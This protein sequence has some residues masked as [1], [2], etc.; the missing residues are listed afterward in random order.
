MSESPAKELKYGTKDP[1]GNELLSI[2]KSS[3]RYSGLFQLKLISDKRKGHSEFSTV[4]MAQLQ[5]LFLELKK[6]L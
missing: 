1:P 3:L 2:G 4:I 5:E 6:I